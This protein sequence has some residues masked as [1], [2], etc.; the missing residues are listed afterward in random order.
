MNLFNFEEDNL[1]VNDVIKWIYTTQDLQNI[2]SDTKESFRFRRRDLVWEQVSASSHKVKH[3][4]KDYEKNFKSLV[5]VSTLHKLEYIFVICKWPYL[6][7]PM[8]RVL[9]HTTKDRHRSN[10]WNAQTLFLNLKASLYE[11]SKSVTLELSCQ[12]EESRWVC[13]T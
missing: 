6:V 4:G 11:H 2:L 8:S 3:S 9:C 7:I 13:S 5:A 1:N 10:W 12:P